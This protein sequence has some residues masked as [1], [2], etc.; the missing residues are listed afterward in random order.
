MKPPVA[1][2]APGLSP[3]CQPATGTLFRWTRTT[4]TAVC[5]DSDR[6]PV[7]PG[8]DHVGPHSHWRID[9]HNG[10]SL[11][12]CVVQHADGDFRWPAGP[13]GVS[14]QPR[15]SWPPSPTRFDRRDRSVEAAH[16]G[17]NDY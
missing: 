1:F 11:P 13:G 17:K 4:A 7:E 15:R 10:L 12:T 5:R 3:K 16:A 8:Y 9:D 14:A 6:L 2:G